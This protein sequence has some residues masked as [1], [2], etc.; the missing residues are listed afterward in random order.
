M[1]NQELAE[2]YG[3]KAVS[4]PTTSNALLAEQF[5]GKAVSKPTS[6]R[7]TTREEAEKLLEEG[8]KAK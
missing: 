8:D 3:G 5:G 4:G 1:T 2:K 7:Y 6:N